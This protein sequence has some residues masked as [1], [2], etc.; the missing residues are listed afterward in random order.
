L[1]KF[2]LLPLPIDSVKNSTQNQK[3]LVLSDSDD[4]ETDSKQRTSSSVSSS[5]SSTDTKKSS[6][7][8]LL[9]E[10]K[11]I[12]D[13]QA[14]RPPQNTIREP[15]LFGHIVNRK[16]HYRDIR[17][18]K[19]A[20]IFTIQNEVHSIGNMLRLSLLRDSRVLVAGFNIPHPL[21]PEMVLKVQT[22]S[23]TV[24]PIQSLDTSL[25]NL[26]SEVEA[27]EKQFLESF[28]SCASK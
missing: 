6:N 24:H 2:E 13:S 12:P 4:E 20:G 5:S 8:P 26:H 21:T 3:R 27:V 16:V 7:S 9:S 11:E 23:G 19:N 10:E 14:S 25:S 18:I 15:Q 1:I 28:A 17:K 22:R